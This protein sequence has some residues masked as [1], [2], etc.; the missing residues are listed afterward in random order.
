[1]TFLEYLDETEKKRR[2]NVA[3]ILLC[4][5]PFFFFFFCEHKTTSIYWTHFLP[6]RVKIREFEW[7]ISFGLMKSGVGR[8]MVITL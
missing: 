4:G 3:G 2:E 6:W 8:E 7:E 1:M 5:P